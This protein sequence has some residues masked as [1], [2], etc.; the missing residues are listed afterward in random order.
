MGYLFCRH[1]Y[2]DYDYVS[3]MVKDYITQY[4]AEKISLVISVLNPI[5]TIAAKVL[6]LPLV[7]ITQS[8]YHPRKIYK[9]IRWWDTLPEDLPNAVHTVNRVLKDYSLKTVNSMEELCVSDLTIIPSF[10]EFDPLNDKNAIY[11]G[12]MT[13]NDSIGHDDDFNKIWI[14]NNNSKTIYVYTGRMHDSGGKS[15]LLILKNVIEAFKN[16][17]YN[18][19]ITTGV[20]EMPIEYKNMTMPE[21]IQVMEWIPVSKILKKID[22]FIHHGGHGLCLQSVLSNKPSI[23]IPTYDER[24]YNA[25]HIEKLGISKYILP[26]NITPNILKEESM[27]FI[28]DNM[29][30]KKSQRLT[31]AINQANYPGAEGIAELISKIIQ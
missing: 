4:K 24:E 23:I 7:A 14:D 1:G 3:C 16:T 13:W 10:K 11:S 5:V 9:S 15:G 12:I 19:I 6:D 29:F 28:N 26:E 25:R 17:E 2:L 8:C 27:S 30:Y 31:N 18:I 21:N 20:G 22:L